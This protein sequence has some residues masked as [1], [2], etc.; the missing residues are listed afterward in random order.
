MVDILLNLSPIL[1]GIFLVLGAFVLYKGNALYSMALYFLAD[2][3]WLLMSVKDANT[4]GT[5]SILIGIIFSTGVMFKMNTGT[6]HTNLNKNKK[7]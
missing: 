7:D 2:L 6:F 5:I 1:G 3:C 4:F